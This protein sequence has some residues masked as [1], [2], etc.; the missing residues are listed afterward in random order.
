MMKKTLC[1]LCGV[2]SWAKE[3]DEAGSC[4]LKWLHLPYEKILICYAKSAVALG[5][6]AAA[7]SIK[8]KR[9]SGH[10]QV[11][12]TFPSTPCFFLSRSFYSIA[13]LSGGV[14]N[15]PWTVGR[16]EEKEVKTRWA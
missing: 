13:T 6:L 1:R 14:R 3:K 11:F 12:L 10:L 2:S 8:Q 15:Q 9:L 4:I 16:E 7:F 5:G